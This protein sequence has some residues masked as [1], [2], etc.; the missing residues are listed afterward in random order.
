MSGEQVE[1]QVEGGLWFQWWWY[2]EGGKREYGVVFGFVL[3]GFD[4]GV[5]WA[6]IGLG[7]RVGLVF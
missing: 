1:G 3:T 6:R 7:K 4:H 2:G 5:D